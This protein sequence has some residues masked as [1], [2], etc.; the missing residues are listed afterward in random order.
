MIKLL[1][2]I[3]ILFSGIVSCGGGG[4]SGNTGGSSSTSVSISTNQLTFT[5]DVTD[6]TPAQQNISGTIAG[7]NSNIRIDVI[8]TGTAI[9]SATF[10]LTGGD[11]GQLTVTPESPSVLGAGTYTATITI[12]VCTDLANSCVGNSS[13]IPGSPK[14][15]NVTYTVTA[16]IVVSSCSPAT[17]DSTQDAD[18]STIYTKSHLL[19]SPTPIYRLFTPRQLADNSAVTL[20]YM[21]HE[22]A[23]T[24][25]GVMVLISGG[26]LRA[27]IQGTDGSQP[28]NSSGNFLVRS[29]NRYQ[30]AGYR[31]ITIDRPSDSVNTNNADSTITF[32]AY[33]DSRAGVNID[34]Y[35]HSMQHAVDIAS[36]LK[37]ENTEGY[38]VIISGTSRG[39]ISAAA[40]NTLVAGIAMSSPLTSA[41]TSVPFAGYPVGSTALPLS[42]IKRSSHIMLHTN[43][44]CSVTLPANSRNLF[45]DLNTAG[46]SVAGNEV[47]GG[48]QDT[49]RNDVCGAFDFHGFNGIETCAVAKETAWA[50]N[51]I[52]GL[53]TNNA[54]I[55]NSQIVGL[56]NPVTLTASDADGDSLNFAV[57]YATT[58]L[59]GTVTT[60][61]NG[62]VT[63]TA[64]VGVDG[65]IDTFAFIVTDGKGGVSTAVV[66]I[67]LP[68]LS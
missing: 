43:D 29:A 13:Q 15:V 10:A 25:K 30:A 28:T 7:A 9:A 26:G 58:S 36:I 24:P 35:R 46:I 50:N 53:A 47:S 16:S 55:A 2:L 42:R 57:P 23:A 48:F 67:T 60:D 14:V 32:G 56:G 68:A 12:Y 64:P 20:D 37:R 65:T 41:P 39:S 62:T 59:G 8:I 63:Y 17:G 21:V 19:G 33:G 44:T 27:R 18:G 3:S 6:A 34:R 31:V 1:V 49:I 40:M 38:N 45:N 5:A 4:G 61:N 52:S 11:N 22:P 51:L 66:S 54:P